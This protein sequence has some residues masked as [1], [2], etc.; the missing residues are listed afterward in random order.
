MATTINVGWLN[1]KNGDKFAPKTLSSQ[2][3]TSEGITLENKIAEDMAILENE[4]NTALE[5]K[6]D[7]QH[8][9][10]DKYYTESEI[11][12]KLE[13]VNGSLINI[14]LGSKNYETKTDAQAKLDEAKDYADTVGNTVKNDLLNGAGEAFDTLKELGDL[15]DENQDAIEALETIAANKADKDHNH[16]NVYY[17]K[18]QIDGLELITVDDIDTICGA[19]I[20]KASEVMF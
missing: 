4:M 15:I 7:A 9:H 14:T 6:A 11:D 17:T 19:N 3:I 18:E 2:V 1:D 8:D 10:N 16:D 5:E 20:Q 13:E 12:V